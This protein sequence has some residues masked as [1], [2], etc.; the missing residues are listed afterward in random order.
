MNHFAVLDGLRF[1]APPDGVW[2]WVEK[3]TLLSEITYCD[4]HN[5]NGNTSDN[6]ITRQ[7]AYNMGLGWYFGA[8]DSG[9]AAVMFHQCN[10]IYLD[11]T[12]LIYFLNSIDNNALKIKWV[13]TRYD[14]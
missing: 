11:R 1:P 9:G 14:V 12:F 6:F 4:D 10:Y 7:S 3:A 8:M 2:W 13:N 5:R